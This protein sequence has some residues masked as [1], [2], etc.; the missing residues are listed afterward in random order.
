MTSWTHVAT[1]RTRAGFR[2]FGLFVC[3][4]SR[5]RVGRGGMPL[6]GSVRRPG[7]WR[8]PSGPLSTDPPSR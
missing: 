8:R 4:F 6:E 1:L 3:Q 2:C 7:L 5:P